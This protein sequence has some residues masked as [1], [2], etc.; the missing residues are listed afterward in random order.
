MR[1]FFTSIDRGNLKLLWEPRGNWPET[2]IL[3]LCREMNLVH[4]VDPFVSRW[5]TP[6]FIYFRLH[7]GKGF[8]HVFTHDEL[9]GLAKLIPA[10]TPAY[11]MFNNINMLEDARKFQALPSL[12]DRQ[13][14][15]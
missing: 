3:S 8:K 11:V 7:G 12:G 1:E 2:L 10:D 9:L 14:R 13:D 15:L 5:V 4:A 6:E